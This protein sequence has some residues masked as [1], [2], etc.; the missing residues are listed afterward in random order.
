MEK[1]LKHARPYKNNVFTA[2]LAGKLPASVVYEDD[3]VLAF[4]DAY[5]FTRGHMLIIPKVHQQRLPELNG[6]TR[7][8]LFEIGHQLAAAVRAS[9]IPG[10]DVNFL[11]NDGHIANQSVPHV[12]LH[13]IPR[14][15]GD[16]RSILW[17]LATGFANPARRVNRARLDAD[18]AIIKAA[19]SELS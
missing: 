2:I 1:P 6:T 19:L 9:E 18:A 7:Q 3:L 13:V 11:I 15:K 12:H 5:P 4:M 10:D 17:R 14:T 16:G 8:R